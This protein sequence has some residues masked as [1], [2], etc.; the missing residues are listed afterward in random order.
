MHAI[1]RT[2]FGM[3]AAGLAAASLGAAGTASAQF[4]SSPSYGLNTSYGFENPVPSAVPL[5][6]AELDKPS[7][8]DRI[9]FPPVV[10]AKTVY[11]IKNGTLNACSIA[12]G[13]TLWTFGAKLQQGAAVVAGSYVYAGSADGTVYRVNASSGAGTRLYRTKDKTL[14]S[15]KT[16][17]SGDLGGSSLYVSSNTGLAAIDL[18]TG[19]LKWTASGDAAGHNETIMLDDML[20]VGTFESGA[21]T[22]NTYYAIDKATGKT[23]W[24]LEG[25]HNKLLKA[26]GDRLY[27]NNDWP[28]NDTSTHVA[29]VDTVNAKT[30]KVTGSRQYVNVSTA[31]DPLYQAP[32][33]V[34][35]DG[36]DI[37]VL[38]QDNSIF[39]YN[40]NDDPDVVAAGGVSDRGDFIAGPYDGKMFFQNPNN[41]GIH[42]R[43]LA[44]QSTVYYEGLDNPASRVDFINAGM[45]V[46]QTDGEIYSLNV[47]TGKA[48]FRF[49]TQARN[50]GPFQVAGRTLL[51]QAEGKLYAFALPEELAKPLVTGSTGAF[52]KAQAGLIIDGKEKQF[53]PGMMTQSNRMFVPMRFLMET[54]GAK[55][56]YDAASKQ[57]RITYGTTAFII[58]EDSAFATQD[59]KQVPLSYAPATLNGSLYVPIGDIGKLLGIGVVWEPGPRNVVITTSTKAK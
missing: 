24:K 35:V 21:I 18:A 11:Y 1:R 55:V 19:K 13:K 45:Y 15:L 49:Q 37:Y 5:W 3:L 10:G 16:D 6:S 59:G 20:L 38:T 33:F 34:T 29:T 47:S 40:L 53:Q 58:K 54:I 44:D 39:S 8:T 57:V 27:F 50:F 46:G 7:G 52:V 32:K 4:G 22:V 17:A 30:G 2:L 28:R 26:D 56:S 41:L 43:K 51:V 14:G 25:S 31:L 23:L 12:T 36:N 48:K 9:L 42:G